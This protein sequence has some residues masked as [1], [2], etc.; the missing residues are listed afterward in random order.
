[1][2]YEQAITELESI[3]ERIE[4]GKVGLEESLNEYRRG[5]ALLK[6]CRSVVEAA[7]QEIR[8]EQ[9]SVVSGQLSGKTDPEAD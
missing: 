2:T 3:V 8:K 5:T 4:Q 9:G 6:R 1:M 7:E